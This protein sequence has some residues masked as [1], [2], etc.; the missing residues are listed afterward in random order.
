[1][2]LG[3]SACGMLATWRIP[4]TRPLCSSLAER[5]RCLPL[6]RCA[7]QPKAVFPSTSFAEVEIAGRSQPLL[8]HA[9]TVCRAFSGGQLRIRSKTSRH[10]SEWI[11]R[12]INDR[13]VQR[14]LEVS[15]GMRFG[16]IF[17]MYEEREMKSL[18]RSFGRC[19]AVSVQKPRCV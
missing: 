7:S 12:Q 10:S 18:F 8:L 17:C 19:V 5:L 9:L 1:M 11:R 4:S 6:L 2:P 3:C 13:Y 16:S 15:R 14:A